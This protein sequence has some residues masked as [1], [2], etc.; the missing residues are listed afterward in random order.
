MYCINQNYKRRANFKGLTICLISRR[1][2]TANTFV[3]VSKLECV[4][5]GNCNLLFKVGLVRATH[6]FEKSTKN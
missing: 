1:E 5:E 2:L 6:V 3:E 4:S